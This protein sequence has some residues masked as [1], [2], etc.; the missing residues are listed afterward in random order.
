MPCSPTRV[1]PKIG[2]A[3]TGRLTSSFEASDSAFA[4][5]AGRKTDVVDVGASL[6]YLRSHIGSQEAQGVAFDFGARKE[7]P[8]GGGRGAIG[9]ALRHAGAGLK[10]Q[11]QRNDLPTRLALGA[12][13]TTAK[14]HVVAAELQNGPREGGTDGGIGAEFKA[15]EAV[16]LRVG[17][18]SR[19]AAMGGTGFDAARGMTLGLGFKRASF[20]L[21]Y[22]AQAAGELGNIHRF[23]MC[24]RW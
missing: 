20:G 13:Y 16:A 4:F 6:K 17:Y 7:H 3:S 8:L 21:D 14:G 23:S 2:R 24:M 10:Y 9:A 15:H 19:S 22:A 11:D 12:A 1:S 5:A 18:T